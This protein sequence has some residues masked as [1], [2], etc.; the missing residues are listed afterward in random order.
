MRLAINRGHTNNSPSTPGT[1]YCGGTLSWT[2]DATDTGWSAKRTAYRRALGNREC[3]P[4]ITYLGGGGS[5]TYSWTVT[6]AGRTWSGSG[7]TAS[8]SVSEPGTYTC[9]FTITPAA[10]SGGCSTPGSASLSHSATVSGPQPSFRCPQYSGELIAPDAE[11]LSVSPIYFFKHEVING[12]NHY[13]ELLGTI[14]RRKRYMHENERNT[15]GACEDRYRI[16]Q[17]IPGQVIL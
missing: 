15:S 9:T 14:T 16:P 13:Y 17:W 1:L 11:I 5:P 8:V 6:G 7:K 12:A 10:R 3:D 4:E 2:A